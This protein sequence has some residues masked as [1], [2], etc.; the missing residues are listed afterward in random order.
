MSLS[1]RRLFKLTSAGVLGGCI[2]EPRAKAEATEPKDG[3]EWRRLVE[4]KWPEPDEP[5]LFVGGPMDG[6]MRVVSS[7]IDVFRCAVKPPISY[8]WDAEASSGD[9]LRFESYR[10]TWIEYRPIGGPRSGRSCM[11]WDHL[12]PLDAAG[13]LI[14]AEHPD[15]IDDMELDY[16]CIARML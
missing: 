12:E 3:P 15:L 4:C 8:L 5:M 11:V 9:G 10:R 16:I 1:R 2:A 6:E 13:H 7:G 14:H